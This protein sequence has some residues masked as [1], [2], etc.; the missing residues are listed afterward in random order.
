MVQRCCTSAPLTPAMP[1]R[2]ECTPICAIIIADCAHWPSLP[3]S[4]L[5]PPPSPLLPPTVLVR[6]PCLSSAVGGGGRC[7]LSVRGGAL[8]LSV[9]DLGQDHH[10]GLAAH[11]PRQNHAGVAE[12]VPQPTHSV[13]PLLL[14]PPRGQRGRCRQFL[15]GRTAVGRGGAEALPLRLL[16]SAS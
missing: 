3:P 11:G 7:V 4:P 9:G 12:G 8:P 15:S 16:C 1:M 10:A 14:Q 6:E 2:T 13:L 5:P